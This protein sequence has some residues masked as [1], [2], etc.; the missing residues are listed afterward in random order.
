[1]MMRTLFHFPLCGYSRAIRF[2]LSEKRLDFSLVYESPWD[3][4]EKLQEL[5][6]S[7]TLPVLSDINGTVVYGNSAIREYI[8][9]SYLDINLLGDDPSK[10][11]EARR[12]ADWF[13]FIFYNDVYFDIINEKI[14]KRFMKNVDKTP[15][16]SCIRN[17]LSKLNMHLEYI[18]WLVDRRNWLA[19]QNFSI[20]DIYAASFISVL[21]YLGCVPWEKHEIA[22]GWYARI[23]SRPSFRTILKDNL[24]QIQPSKDYANPDF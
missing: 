16:P 20:A 13:D 22:K 5:N 15:N 21:D 11:A 1:M 6:I 23:K 14:L 8:E 17:A 12:I 7:G 4:S 10:R 2:M 19:G 24:S 18:S 3:V 9:E